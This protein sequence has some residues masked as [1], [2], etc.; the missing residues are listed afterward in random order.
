MKCGKCMFWEVFGKSGACRIG[1]CHNAK[2]NH[3]DGRSKNAMFNSKETYG[4]NLGV[5]IDAKK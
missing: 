5:P 3:G 1:G 2:Y 4:C